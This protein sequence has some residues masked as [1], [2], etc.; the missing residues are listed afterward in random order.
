MASKGTI[1]LLAGA[2]ALLLMSG[3]KK[4]RGKKV[5]RSANDSPPPPEEAEDLDDEDE[6]IFESGEEES[7]DEP[8]DAD[9]EDELDDSSAASVLAR[10]M[11][12]EGRARIGKLYQIK[13]GD[14]PLEVCREALFGSRDVVAEP[15]MR[16]VVKDLLV[17]IDCAPWNQALYGLALEDLKEGHANIDSYFTQKGVSFN[18]VYQDNQRRILN[19]FRPTS[20]AGH[21]FALIWIPMINLDLL[22]T[23]GRV[24][25]EG[26]YYP[27]TENGRGGSMIDPPQEI[28]DLEFDEVSADEVGC[29]LPEGDYR[30]MV[31]ATG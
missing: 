15:G 12:S 8:E 21:K 6:E 27:D 4:K 13:L 18:P 20:E 10:N 29:D 5:A 2:G 7:D 1:L 26:M 24:T 30:R 11:D 25:T 23:E 22:D 14:T 16:Q 19:G 31:V 28:L 17:R 9:V 3:K